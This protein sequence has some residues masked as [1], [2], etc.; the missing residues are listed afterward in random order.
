MFVNISYIHIDS[1]R[2]RWCAYDITP[3]GQRFVMEKEMNP[4]P[5]RIANVLNWFEELKRLSVARK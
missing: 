2:I 4:P 3:D 1:R 5:R